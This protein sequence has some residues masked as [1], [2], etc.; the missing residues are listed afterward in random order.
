MVFLVI[1]CIIAREILWLFLAGLYSN[2]DP[3]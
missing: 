1:T 3:D 2:L